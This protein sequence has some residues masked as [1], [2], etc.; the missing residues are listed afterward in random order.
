MS[1]IDTIY[2]LTKE[3]QDEPSVIIAA[4]LSFFELQRWHVPKSWGTKEITWKEM[5]PT[6][7]QSSCERYKITKVKVV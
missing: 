1:L 3:E 4:S 2:V 7:M 6:E 5:S